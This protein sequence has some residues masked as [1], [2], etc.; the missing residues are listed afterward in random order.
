MA[1]RENEGHV[2]V[3]MAGNKQ[4]QKLV[5]ISEFVN[6]NS[7]NCPELLICLIFPESMGTEEIAVDCGGR[8]RCRYDTQNI[9]GGF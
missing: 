5:F 1:E 4:Q 8:R 3:I 9:V 2:A 7:L 6:N